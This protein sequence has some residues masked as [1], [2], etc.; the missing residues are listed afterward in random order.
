MLKYSITLLNDITGRAVTFKVKEGS[1][2]K[3]V[4]YLA[5]KLHHSTHYTIIGVSSAL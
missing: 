1:R 4:K 5:E 2:L 3:A